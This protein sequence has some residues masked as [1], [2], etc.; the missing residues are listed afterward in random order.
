[1]F[2]T[3]FN[4][5]CDVRWRARSTGVADFFKG[6]T[7]SYTTLT[8]EWLQSLAAGDAAAN[9]EIRATEVSRSGAA[10]RVGTLGTWLSLSSDREWQMLDQ[11]ETASWVLTLEIRR[12]TTVAVSATITLQVFPS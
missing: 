7:G 2:D 6:Q 8:N 5:N 12:G 9:Y 11:A 10:T 4:F 1:M 3:N